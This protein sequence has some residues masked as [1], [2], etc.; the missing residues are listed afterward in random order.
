[1]LLL[2]DCQLC[3]IS[4][5]ANSCIALII[6]AGMFY[7]LT[8][9]VLLCCIFYVYFFFVVMHWCHSLLNYS[10]CVCSDCK[11]S[12]GSAFLRKGVGGVLLSGIVFV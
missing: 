9:E 2:A 3:V 7:I 6:L 5:I 10:G 11:C 4:V 1:M 12:V 8:A